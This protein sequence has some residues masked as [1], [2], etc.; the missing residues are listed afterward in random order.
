M[1]FPS[2]KAKEDK[3]RKHSLKPIHSSELSPQISS[4]VSGNVFCHP[5]RRPK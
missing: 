2:R 3:P 1:G 5:Y 4:S